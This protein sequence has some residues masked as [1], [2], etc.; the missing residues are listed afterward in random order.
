MDKFE[1]CDGDWI[2]CPTCKGNG[3]YAPTGGPCATCGGAGGTRV[4]WR[5]GVETPLFLAAGGYVG[6]MT[7][8]TTKRPG[9]ALLLG[10]AA[11]LAVATWTSHHPWK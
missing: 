11:G 7:L 8:L 1:A 4:R 6:V 2:S 5:P 3:L 10:L 9:R